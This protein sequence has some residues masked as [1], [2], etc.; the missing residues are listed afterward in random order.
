MIVKSRL[1]VPVSGAPGDAHRFGDHLDR[2]V[3][4][5][6]LCGQVGTVVEPGEAKQIIVA[7]Q[8]QRLVEMDRWPSPGSSETTPMMLCTRE[9]WLGA[10]IST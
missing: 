10:G 6:G 4:V 1:A 2:N 3:Q 8:Q 7:G 9:S 5:A